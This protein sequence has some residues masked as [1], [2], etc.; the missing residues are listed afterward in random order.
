M[1]IIPRYI[2]NKGFI[3]EMN[4]PERPTWMQ[5]NLGLNN[6]SLCASSITFLIEVKKQAI[7]LDDIINHK[8][9]FFLNP[10]KER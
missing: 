1:F 9:L 8:K 3:E 2:K 10:L 7:G 5:Y 6:K 4:W